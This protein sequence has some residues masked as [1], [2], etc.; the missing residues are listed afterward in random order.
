MSTNQTPQE[1]DWIDITNLVRDCA[2]QC[3][4]YSHPFTPSHEDSSPLD[5]G[6]TVDGFLQTLSLMDTPH[7]T[8]NDGT[9][10]HP[11]QH[12]PPIHLRDAMSALELGD[13]RMD[14]CE[15]PLYTKETDSNEFDSTKLSH[16]TVTHPPRIAPKDVCDGTT[17]MECTNNH[18]SPCPSLLPYWNTLSLS[19]DS[20]TAILPLVL[21]QYT[22]LEAYTGVHSGGSNAAETLFCCMWCQFGVL[23]DMADRLLGPFDR[24]EVPTDELD[25][26]QWVLLASSMGVVR[27][28]E[29]VRSIVID[30]DIYEE[31]DFGVEWEWGEL[32]LCH[33]TKEDGSTFT[34]MDD[35]TKSRFGLDP[36]GGGRLVNRVW[37][38]AIFK[39]ETYKE[40]VSDPSKTD[41][42]QAMILLLRAQ[43]SFYTSIQLLYNLNDHNVVDFTKAATKRSKETVELLELLQCSP[44][45]ERFAN[46]RLITTDGR[47]CDVSWM[48]S[49]KTNDE[50][51]LFLVASFDPFVVSVVFSAHDARFFQFVI[52]KN[53]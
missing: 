21:L 47:V 22:A 23:R 29:V 31:E 6:A 2:S 18:L 42:I 36:E 34:V 41:P 44:S 49:S 13:K 3:L 43:Q 52:L 26:A 17:P 16:E 50:C 28:A 7:P 15:I 9:S 25:V 8:P 32:K 51:Y 38:R 53:F 24:N 35:S 10:H 39:L 12:I 14:C 40:S 46:N 1:E 48:S 20:P 27:I 11:I 19:A 37:E 30:A 33:R 4:T 5:G 45:L